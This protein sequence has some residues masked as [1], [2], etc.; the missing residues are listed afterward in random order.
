MLLNDTTITLALLVVSTTTVATMIGLE[1]RARRDL[2]TSLLPT[3]PIMLIAALVAL[4]A[5][6]HLLNLWGVQTG[7]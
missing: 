7:R 3:T 1:S 5:L 2:N 4:L 6:V